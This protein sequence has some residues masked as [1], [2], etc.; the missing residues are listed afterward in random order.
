MISMISHRARGRVGPR[1]PGGDKDWRLRAL[2]RI[3]CAAALSLTLH[4]PASAHAVLLGSD[5][6]HGAALARAPHHIVLRFNEPVRPLFVRLLDSAGR[7][8][9]L[10]RPARAVDRE[11]HAHLPA[12]LGDG[13][14]V[15]SF[16]VVSADGHPIAGAILFAIGGAPGDAPANA[17]GASAAWR[18]AATVN[19]ALHLIYLFLAA[20]G[21][22][23]A[24]I[25]ARD[26]AR[27]GRGGAL[28]AAAAATGLLGIALH[29]AALA[30]RWDAA[31]GDFWRAALST[32]QAA[33]ALASLGG[34]ALAFL[35][36]PRIGGGAGAG[37]AGAGA[38]L[39]LAAAGAT[40]H[41]VAAGW[42]WW[43]V[44]AVHV[45]AAGFWLG[46]L[47][48]LRRALKV[49][50][51]AG[52]AVLR[53]FS[54]IAV[55][56]VLVLALAGAGL[57]LQRMDGLSDL[58]STD[59]GRLVLA[60]LV[61]AALLVAIAARNKLAL[62]PA[63]ARGD[64]ARRLRNAI[65]LELVLMSGVVALAALLAHSDPHAG[66]AHGHPRTAP[67]PAG[68]T[69]RLEA[70]ERVAAVEIYPA[71]PGRNT[72]TVS[73]AKRNGE[74]QAPLEAALELALPGAGIEGLTVKL[75]PL[76]PGTFAADIAEI[77]LPGRWQLRIDALIDD[78]EKAIFRGEIEIR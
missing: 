12:D 22:L 8:R 48:P 13:T 21:L 58:A 40:G 44:G 73:F 34:L 59:Y 37:L 52:I 70:G 68:A 15:A 9:A 43:L 67:A 53:R 57:A 66:H 38:L 42:P 31:S 2:L 11:V 18:I 17:D 75:S 50:P 56:T 49:A 7:E 5:P 45:A 23:F 33:S 71:K 69:L 27:G 30:G 62:T 14:Y 10:P 24:A 46:S 6:P 20:G 28:A 61:G 77:A 47:P 63:L 16:R 39:A 78:F 32:P 3:V 1:L 55:P 25:V 54:R 64:D 35:A 60:K 65:A 41:S 29:G 26:R 72:L 76:A 19:R 36:A 4:A 51:D 74:A